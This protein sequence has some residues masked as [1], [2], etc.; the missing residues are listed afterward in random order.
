[1]KKKLLVTVTALVMAVFCAFSLA[2]C[3]GDDVEG[4]YYVYQSGEIVEGA[5][6]TLD[7]GKVTM[8]QTAM[9]QTVTLSGTYKV[10]G[11]TVTVTIDVMGASSSQEITVVSDGVLKDNDGIYYCKQ[12]KTPPKDGAE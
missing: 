7:D 6:M 11:S 4:T 2:A 1:M 12:G 8:T 3:N 9:G 10:S 5:S